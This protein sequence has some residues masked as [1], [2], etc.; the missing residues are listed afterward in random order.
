MNNYNE[1]YSRHYV[2][3]GFGTQAQDK[4]ARAKVLVIGAG[5]LG[6][7]VLQYLAAVGVG[8]IGLADDDVVALS[9]LQ[10][11]VLYAT[12]DVGKAKATVAALKLQQLNPDITI[13]SYKIMVTSVN[14]LELIA[15]YDIVVDC[16]DNFAARYLINDACALVNK[17]LVF[18][19]VYQYE[20]QVAIFNV[21]DTKGN[22]T[23][24]RHLFPTPPAPG[25][26]PDCNEAGVLGILPGT[27]GIMQA[28][29]VIKIVTGIGEILLNKILTYN[30]LTYDTYTINIVE[31]EQGTAMLP[32]SV[33]AFK[34][35]DYNWLCNGIEDVIPV[36]IA[37]EFYSAI[38]APDTLVID[39]REPNEVPKAKFKNLNIPL[40]GLSENIS[41]IGVSNIIV[42]CQ[43]GKRS[44]RAAQLL[45][46]IYGTTKNISHLQGGIL[47]LKDNIE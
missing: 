1:R 17:P 30:A 23:N 39:V 18:G 22:K 3:P 13:Y 36:I 24:Y 47:A 38:A 29:E 25:D 9:N 41:E 8:T 28:T 5:G 10:R 19:A 16:T 34:G 14:A 37:A 42:F 43:S 11:Q 46:D 27:I 26:A 12:P 15:D 4:L 2:L 35:T 40:S 32:T 31:N 21:A 20:G 33:E 45:K 44:L 6:C 7:P